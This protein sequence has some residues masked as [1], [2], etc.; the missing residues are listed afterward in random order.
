[1]SGALQ[2]SDPRCKNPPVSAEDAAALAQL[3]AIVKALAAAKVA[4]PA[5]APTPASEPASKPKP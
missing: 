2:R 5:P 1:M 3:G 4:A